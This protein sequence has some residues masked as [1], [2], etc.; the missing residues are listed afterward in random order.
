[1]R[2]GWVW[3]ISAAMKRSLAFLAGLSV[4]LPL[5][6]TELSA[7]SGGGGKTHPDNFKPN[8]LIVLWDT[9]RAD[10]LS[11]Y[12]YDRPTSP[13]LDAFAKDAT[14]YD[15]ATPTGMWTLVTHTS[16]FTGLTETESGAHASWL[17]LDN[18][19]ETL[20]ERLGESGYETFAF[21]ANI[22]VGP[23]TNLTQGFEN[24]FTSYPPFKMT[25]VQQSSR[26]VKASRQAVKDKLVPNDASVE[27]SPAFTGNM[28][29]NWGKST[30][31]D[32]APVAAQAFDDFLGE[33]T[34]PTRPFFAYI[35]MM[36]AHSPR[37]P[38][39]ESRK[40]VASQEEID[41]G[42]KTDS[43][44][45]ALNEYI[46]GKREYS[47]AEKTA[48]SAIY[49]ASIHDLD[50]ATQKIFDSLKTRGI[51]DDTVV[52]IVA[53]HGEA[54]GE[55][56]RYE[57]RWSLNE[58]LLHVPLV[59]RYPDKFPK[60][61][62]VHARVSTADLYATINQL[63]GLDVPA[64]THS[65][66]LI[67]RKEGEQYVYAQLLDPFAQQLASM[68]EAHPDVVLE[69]WQRS[70]CAIYQDDWKMVWASGEGDNTLY[71]LSKDPREEQSVFDSEAAKRDELK[72]ALYD[73]EKSL[74]PYDPDARD[75][76][77]TM[78]QCMIDEITEQLAGKKGEGVNP[79]HADTTQMLE[80]LGYAAPDSS[81]VPWRDYCGPYGQEMEEAAKAAEAAK[82]P[83]Q[84]QAEAD[85]KKL[86]CQP[87]KAMME[88][89]AKMKAKA[90]KTKAGK[91]KAG[92][93]AEEAVE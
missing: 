66:S 89:K 14:V 9:T 64:G 88:R 57:H 4:L 46:V 38:S 29:D 76:L 32:A 43:S 86:A 70:Y 79:E 56:Q 93:A 68:A 18:R 73:W 41:L 92:K 5:A 8:V 60:G 12:G 21:S 74:R 65:H 77:E 90:G 42:L 17:W 81:D 27:L 19:H 16:I 61:E 33:R 85:A 58:E 72:Q 20:A 52:I 3:V 78:R 48:I 51:L 31:K 28:K 40:A 23:W 1:M 91:A 49:D 25:P 53:D 83:E 7:C 36:E 82:T 13:N 2:G 35:N 62:R 34:D 71:D 63:A 24:L 55:H 10:H 22:I 11:L 80:A 69:P 47:D 50:T 30:F 67:G 15:R 44:L 6:V 26:Y 39:M 59:I 45:F 75:K 87:F 54:L 37:I 84:I